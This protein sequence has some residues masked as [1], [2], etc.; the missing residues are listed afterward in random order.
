MSGSSHLIVKYLANRISRRWIKLGLQ[1][2]SVFI[3]SGD[4]GVAGPMFELG[5]NNCLGADK[6]I[7]SPNWPNTCPYV[8]VV[9]AT[10]V[11]PKRSVRDP[12]SAPVDPLGEPWSIAYSS[13]GG[14]SNIFPQPDYQKDAV[15]K[16]LKDHNPPYPYYESIGNSSFGQDG[17]IYNRLGR[18]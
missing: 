13:G 16:Y 14:F 4:S 2:H 15:T 8:T 18:S 5:D 17:G 1:G 7:F 11:Y 12:E 9:G 3:A 6:T 10:K